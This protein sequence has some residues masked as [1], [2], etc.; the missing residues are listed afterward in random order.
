VVVNFQSCP[1]APDIRCHAL[2]SNSSHDYGWRMAQRRTLIRILVEEPASEFS[3]Y[4]HI[5]CRTAL[6]NVTSAYIRIGGSF[7]AGGP[8]RAPA[9]GTMPPGCTLVSVKR[10]AFQ[11]NPRK[12][13]LGRHNPA[14]IYC[15]HRYSPS[16][17]MSA[18]MCIISARIRGS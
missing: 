6:R 12:R 1:L 16:D 3:A 5:D 15:G 18:W 2:G 10:E 13:P 9:V 11:P 8:R 4:P 7:R 17:G 14:M